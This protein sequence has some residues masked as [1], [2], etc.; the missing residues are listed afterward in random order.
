MENKK[1]ETD[2]VADAGTTVSSVGAHGNDLV[3]TFGFVCAS[4]DN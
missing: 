2:T 3:S 4:R 1:T